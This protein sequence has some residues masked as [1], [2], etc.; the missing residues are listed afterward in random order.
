MRWSQIM[1]A[2]MVGFAQHARFT[3]LSVLLVLFHSY[4]VTTAPILIECLIVQVLRET[5]PAGV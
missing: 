4:H 3:L 5:V 2:L 1:R